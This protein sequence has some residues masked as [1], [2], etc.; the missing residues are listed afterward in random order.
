VNK[1]ASGDDTDLTAQA[2]D[3]LRVM[4]TEKRRDAFRGRESAQKAP[5]IALRWQV[6][7]PRGFVQEEDFESSEKAL[8]CGTPRLDF[9]GIHQ[10]L[11]R[12]TLLHFGSGVHGCGADLNRPPLDYAI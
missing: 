4:A 8:F 12:R 9:G 2:A 5:H 3:F 10:R 1:P 6:Q 11:G 7:P